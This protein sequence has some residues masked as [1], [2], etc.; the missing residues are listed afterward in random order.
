MSAGTSV[1]GALAQVPA[2]R[3]RPSPASSEPGDSK[4]WGNAWQRE[5]E[6]LQADAWFQGALP[7]TAAAG[8]VVPDQPM[9]RLGTGQFPHDASIARRADASD[10]RRW[11]PDPDGRAAT[12]P[13]PAGE[14]AGIASR[15]D[16]AP[17]S[18]ARAPEPA[19]PVERPVSSGPAANELS[20][21]AVDAL[22]AGRPLLLDGTPVADEQGFVPAEAGGD[23]G[24]DTDAALGSRSLD[25]SAADPA[26][27]GGKQSVPT[28]ATRLL[29][30]MDDDGL[31]TSAPRAAVM[32]ALPAAAHGPVAGTPSQRAA[33]PAGQAG[34]ALRIEPSA[35]AAGSQPNAS[36]SLP[37]ARVAPGAVQA[38]FAPGQSTQAAADG[39]QPLAEEGSAAPSRPA[40]GPRSLAGIERVL[41]SALGGQ[42]GPRLHLSWDGQAVTVWVG[43]D[44]ATDPALLLRTVQQVLSQQGLQLSA[45]V[46]NGRT[47]VQALPGDGQ[48]SNPAP[49]S[50]QAAARGPRRFPRGVNPLGSQPSSNQAEN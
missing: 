31:M 40:A 10:G 50:P 27:P 41:A 25:G 45:L 11:V 2:M 29:D 47:I 35:A 38:P 21:A 22:P 44:G 3:E 30:V 5:M 39:A 33:S 36:A 7:G 37:Q 20:A 15:R 23:T 6:R 48:E 13:R 32:D 43:V 14:A 28:V 12:A 8:H 9:G 24:L 17:S 18:Q 19:S 4:R 46:C 16:E 42:P 1:N 49:E 26:R 34:A